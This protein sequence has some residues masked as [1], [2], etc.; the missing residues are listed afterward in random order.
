[1]AI[2]FDPFYSFVFF[3]MCMEFKPLFSLSLLSLETDSVMI[4]LMSFI[5]QTWKFGVMISFMFFLFIE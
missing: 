1:M 3:V 5:S 2:C 4:F